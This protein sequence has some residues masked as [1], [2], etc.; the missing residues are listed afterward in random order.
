MQ[1]TRLDEA[2]AGIKLQGEISKTSQ[3]QI[4]PPYGKKQRGAKEPLHEGKREE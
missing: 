4:T 2:Q 1:N 3:M